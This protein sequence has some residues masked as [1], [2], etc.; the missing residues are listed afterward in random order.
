VNRKDEIGLALLHS[1]E[2]LANWNR[3]ASAWCISRNR[4]LANAGTEDGSRT[5]E[6]A[7]ADST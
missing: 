2:R 5:E 3:I 6:F 7:D 4:E 1:I